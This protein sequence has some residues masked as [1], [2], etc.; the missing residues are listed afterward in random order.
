MHCMEER[1]VDINLIAIRR[2]AVQGIRKRPDCE[3]DNDG[4]K[5]HQSIRQSIRQAESA[6]D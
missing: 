1:I 3:L 6:V 5:I 2:C 4:I